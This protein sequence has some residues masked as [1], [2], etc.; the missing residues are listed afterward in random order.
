MKNNKDRSKRINRKFVERTGRRGTRSKRPRLKKY[1]KRK[2]SNTKMK[3]G[4]DTENPLEEGKKITFDGNALLWDGNPDTRTP[5]ETSYPASKEM[6]MGGN[7]EVLGR[8][9]FGQVRK[10]TIKDSE[11]PTEVGIVAAVKIM[12]NGGFEGEEFKGFVY[13]EYNFQ[14]KLSTMEGHSK[15]FA[16]VYNFFQ[17]MYGKQYGIVMELLEPK[18][19]D[20]LELSHLIRLELSDQE[21]VHY[22]LE[23]AR[24]IS[25]THKM[26]I[27][28][29]DLK[30]E[31]VVIAED[32]TSMGQLKLV[33]F[34]ISFKAGREDR[35]GNWTDKIDCCRTIIAGSY[36][37]FSYELISLYQTKEKERQE[38]REAAESGITWGAGSDW[39]SYGI[40]V[41]EMVMGSCNSVNYPGLV[42][43]S[44]GGNTIT[45]LDTTDIPRFFRT[46]ELSWEGLESIT[47]DVMFKKL[48][49]RYSSKSDVDKLLLRLAFQFFVK[50]PKERPFLCLD[51]DQMEDYNGTTEGERARALK[52]I[53]AKL[54]SLEA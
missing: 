6:N 26:G 44:I 30:P 15:Y 17:I 8:G 7:G 52:D 43:A 29:G 54:E 3:G 2:K 24:A 22:S 18:Y 25:A 50:N 28:H 5:K 12:M 21:K 35:D 14:R 36:L 49:N 33:D 53:V 4:G 45:R 23:L 34:G 39:W 9:N 32:G 51:T 31:N 40:I 41:Y 1:S 37:Y 19:K 42:S 13:R 47:Y 48:E 20:S 16:K 46:V 38:G 11:I 10:F 27:V